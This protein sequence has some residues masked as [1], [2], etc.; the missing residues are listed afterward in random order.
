MPV[1]GVEPLCLIQS[2]SSVVSWMKLQKG[3]LSW[4]KS[5][6]VST[7]PTETQTCKQKDTINL[8]KRGI[9]LTHKTVSYINLVME[10]FFQVDVLDDSTDQ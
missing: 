9:K 10:S 2:L 8:L 1:V 4:L 3:L 5:Q 7:T 6:E